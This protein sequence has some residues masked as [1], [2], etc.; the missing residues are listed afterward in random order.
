M[1]FSIAGSGTYDGA[2][3]LKGAETETTT[4]ASGTVVITRGTYTGTYTITAAC[5]IKETDTDDKSKAVSHYDEFTGPA[6]NSINFVETDPGV[7]S[8]AVQTR[9]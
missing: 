4:N 9:D 5:A 3:G 6:G 8:A 1:P 2:G 7:V